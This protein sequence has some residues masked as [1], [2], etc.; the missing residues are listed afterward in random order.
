MPKNAPL[1]SINEL[2]KIVS[3]KSETIFITPK[4]EKTETEFYSKHLNAILS[5]E[6]SKGTD[7]EKLYQ[8]SLDAR[9]ESGFTIGFKVALQL[10]TQSKI[11]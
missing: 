10:L 8:N 2:Y 7:I 4:T 6:K 11:I 9:E 3:N 1:I 5:T